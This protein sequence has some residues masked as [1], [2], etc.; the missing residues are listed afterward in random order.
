MRHVSTKKPSSEF[1]EGR[2]MLLQKVLLIPPYLREYG[3]VG[4]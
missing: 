2:E 1:E 3:D 4:V